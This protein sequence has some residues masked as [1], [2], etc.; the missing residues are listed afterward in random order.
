MTKYIGKWNWVGILV[1]LGGPSLWGGTNLDDILQIA[2]TRSNE[3]KIIQAQ[4]QVGMAE[5]N[6]YR[7]SALP[8]ITSNMAMNRGW[9]SVKANPYAG[10]LDALSPPGAAKDTGDGGK[11]FDVGYDYAWTID[12]RTPIFS[13]GRLGAVYQI[14]NLQKEFLQMQSKM[15]RQGFSLKIIKL[16]L[17]AL[18]AK[19]FLETSVKSESY[20]QSLYA[21]TEIEYQGKSR[22]HI[23]LLRIKTAR[24]MAE[25]QKELHKTRVESALE[26]LKGTAGLADNVTIQLPKVGHVQAAFLA[27]EKSGKTDHSLENELKK[28][29]TALSE[30]TMDYQRSLYWPTIYLTG[31]V[32]NQIVDRGL[33]G[34]SVAPKD[35]IDPDFFNYK[36]GLAVGWTLFDSWA[37]PSRARKAAEQLTIA[38]RQLNEFMWQHRIDLK[39]SR[40]QLVISHRFYQA[41][42]QNVEASQLFYEKVESD[43]RNGAATLSESLSA[44]NELSAAAD[45]R[46]EA[47]V[48]SILAKA[49]FLFIRGQDLYREAK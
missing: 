37:T 23:D 13:F 45:K 24:D 39:N 26:R 38:R 12:F 2:Q 44:Q 30:K 40:K 42:S 6:E 29:K 41:A 7:A 17:E 34:A 9:T 25:A 18:L 28:I 35:I 46:S 14:S 5:V 27:R 22:S 4:N 33:G 21:F 47:Y 49:N 31:N 36:V 19:S 43:Y 8:Q 20:M 48:N 32:A 3:T 10:L 16:Y 1:L 11:K 15:Q